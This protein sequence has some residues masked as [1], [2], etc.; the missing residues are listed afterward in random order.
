MNNQ[1]KILNC[2]INTYSPAETEKVIKKLLL[3]DNNS[4]IVTPNPEIVLL[5]QKKKS[6]QKIINE[7]SLSICDGAG[8]MWAAIFNSYQTTAIPVIRELETLFIFVYSLIRFALDK[9]YATKIIPERITGTDIVPVIARICQNN[10]IPIFFLGAGP[11]VAD[12]AAKKLKSV[13]KKL[14]VAGAC[15]GSYKKEYDQK[16]ISIINKSNTGCLLVA[17]GAPHQEQWIYRNM[18]K[19]P[20]VKLLIGVGG[21]FDFITGEKSLLGG[22]NANRAPLWLRNIHLEWIHRLIKQPSRITRIFNAVAVFPMIIL[23]N[24]LRNKLQ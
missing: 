1:V 18:S 3:S 14:K 22:N 16:L 7:S 19:M 23:I 17:Y 11:K 5:A 24:K 8:L 2:K 12:G 10:K 15:S 4:Y 20:R 13:Y 9:T 21:A 6:Y